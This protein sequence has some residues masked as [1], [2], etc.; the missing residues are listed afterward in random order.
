M[1]W[2]TGRLVGMLWRPMERD[3]DLLALC[4]VG[5]ARARMCGQ[6]LHVCMSFCT[7]HVFRNIILSYFHPVQT[8]ARSTSLLSACQTTLVHLVVSSVQLCGPEMGHVFGAQRS[9]LLEVGG[10]IGFPSRH[11]VLVVF[12]RVLVL[13]PFWR[14]STVWE[15]SACGRTVVLRVWL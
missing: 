2:R 12:P 7:C 5:E 9:C 4:C 1:T 3:R 14:S 10:Q 6:T 8:S 15:R 13:T 11:F